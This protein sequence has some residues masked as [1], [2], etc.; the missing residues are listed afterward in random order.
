MTHEEADK[1]IAAIKPPTE[2]WIIKSEYLHGG[3]AYWG[4]KP[5][6]GSGLTRFR[7]NAYRYES[8]NAAL[9]EAYS[10]REIGWIN[11]FTV[12]KLPPKP[13]LGRGSGTGGR[14]GSKPSPES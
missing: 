8:E 14:A 1:I 12:E 5:Y 9:H 2:Q 11:D 7:A 10:Y 13:R 6:G 3:T 4:E